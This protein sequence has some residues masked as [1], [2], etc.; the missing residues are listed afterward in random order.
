MKLIGSSL[1]LTWNQLIELSQKAVGEGQSIS[2]HSIDKGVHRFNKGQ[3]QSWANI[4]NPDK[5]GGKSLI[6]FDSLPETAKAK[7][8]SREELESL[9]IQTINNRAIGALKREAHAELV[10]AAYL[11]GQKKAEI[12]KIRGSIVPDFNEINALVKEG[13]KKTLAQQTARQAAYLRFWNLL[14]SAI[15]K[16]S[17]ANIV[18]AMREDHDSQLLPGPASVVNLKNW[19]RRYAEGGITALLTKKVGNQNAAWSDEHRAMLFD[20]W[21]EMKKPSKFHAW[22]IYKY[23]CIEKD[24]PYMSERTARNYLDDYL[25]ESAAAMSRYGSKTVLEKFMPHMHRHNGQYSF[26]QLVGD[27]L[28]VGRR[29]LIPA[30]HAWTGKLQRDLIAQINLWLWFDNVTGCIVGYDFALSEPF[31]L[32]RNALKMAAKIHG[33]LPLSVEMDKKMLNNKEMQQLLAQTGI[34]AIDNGGV[35]N[36]KSKMAERHNKEFNSQFRKMVADWIDRSSKTHSTFR[37]G[38]EVKEVLEKGGQKYEYPHVDDAVQDLIGVINAYNCKPEQC[39]GMSRLE[40]LEANVNPNAQKIGDLERA[41]IF[42]NTRIV[43]LKTTSKEN[44]GELSFEVG[45]K[46][47]EYMIPAA[48]YGTGYM[49]PK[50]RVYFD[51]AEPENAALYMMEDEKDTAQDH[52]VSELVWMPTFNRVEVEMTAKD[53]SNL[54]KQQA[55]KKAFAALV[56]GYIET[57]D[58]LMELA[59]LDMASI[60][61]EMM[62]GYANMEV[63]AEKAKQYAAVGSDNYERSTKQVLGS[64]KSGLASGTDHN[65]T[66]EAKPKGKGRYG[67]LLES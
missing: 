19:A 66:N 54:G 27:G 56:E 50:M 49:Q 38:M 32:G 31:E 65:T 64:G 47:Y 62:K 39:Q 26:S 9:A 23:A 20:A 2:F 16:A 67:L 22:E 28:K 52:F 48:A 14:P 5:D 37:D 30:N 7:L 4:P 61:Q 6:D 63:V 59:D 34:K 12:E 45:K 57:K 1:Y 44:R 25:V 42:G 29:V 53:Y 3:S 55:N 40:A 33:V 15:R 41:M 36:P 8:P 17:E 60:G 35:S 24:E 21:A 11:E 18:E 58:G 43:R 10:S 51:E 46:S 13:V